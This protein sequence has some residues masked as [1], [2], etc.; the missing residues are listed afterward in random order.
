MGDLLAVPVLVKMATL[1]LSVLLGTLISPLYGLPLKPFDVAVYAALGAVP[2]AILPLFL[3]AA[4]RRHWQIGGGRPTS[5]G[6]T[7]HFPFDNSYARL[8]DRFFTRQP[9]CRWR[10]RA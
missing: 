5:R 3:V 1:G 6:M 9:P 2:L 7:A 8:P 10:H 4:P